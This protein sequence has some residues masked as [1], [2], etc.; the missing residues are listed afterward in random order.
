MNK[1]TFIKKLTSGLKG[2]G[3]N[4]SQEVVKDYEAHFENE[5]AKGKT[6]EE[7]AKELGVVSDILADFESGK[8]V[9]RSKK[10]L[11][12]ISVVILDIFSYSLM[13]GL[14]LTIITGFTISLISLISSFYLV[15][16]LDMLD[17]IPY[18][19][20][21]FSIFSGLVMLAFAGLTLNLSILLTKYCNELMR[22]LFNWHKE[23]L[24]EQPHIPW[25]KVVYPAIFIRLSLYCVLGVIILLITTYLIGALSTQ[26]LQFWHQWNWFINN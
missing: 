5:E 14:Y 26:D 15:L 7:I 24:S 10:T 16:N 8:A 19:T 11:N 6:E 17:F 1:T 23:M 20:S 4:D 12:L 18:M 9:Y 25:K 22:R 13:F 3:I 21:L 2:L